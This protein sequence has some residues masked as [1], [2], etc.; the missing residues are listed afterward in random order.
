MRMRTFASARGASDGARPGG[1]EH[2]I[3]RVAGLCE[4]ADTLHHRVRQI[5]AARP[6]GGGVHDVG[7]ERR[8]EVAEY[9][10]QVKQMGRAIDLVPRRRLL[11][12]VELVKAV[13]CYKNL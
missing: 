3:V 11:I 2:R 13:N 4:G 10:G 12:P 5:Q 9:E 8:P 6:I 1:A 7:H